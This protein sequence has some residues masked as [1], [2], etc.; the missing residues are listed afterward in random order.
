MEPDDSGVDTPV[1][2]RGHRSR[3]VRLTDEGIDCLPMSDTTP[4]STAAAEPNGDGMACDTANY[5]VVVIGGGFCGASTGILLKRWRP[6]IRVL[7]VEQSDAFRRKVGEA[8]VEVSSI[9]L[10]RVLGLYDHLAREHLPKHGLRYWFTDGANRQ[11]EEMSEVGPAEPPRL[12]SFQLDRTKLDQYLLA[13][14]A[15]EGCEVWRPAKVKTLDD[16][17]P[18]STL[19]L[20]TEDGPRAVTSRWVVDASGRYNFISRRKGLR[21]RVEN[22]R[23]A[24][25]W[26][27]WKGAADFDGR[28]VV[29]D[30]PRS[31]PL[32]HVAASRRLATNH[33]CGYGWWAWA[34]PLSGGETS[35]GVVYDKDLYALPEGTSTVE[36]YRAHL[37]A[38]DGLRQLIEG[39]ELDGDDFLAYSHLPYRSSQYMGRGWAL[40]GDAAAFIDPYY[41]PGLDHASMSIYATVRILVQELNGELDDTAL[42]SQLEEHNGN[43]HRSYD[44]W[45]AALYLGKYE[46]LGDAELTRTAFLFDTAMYYLGV[47][48]PLCKD[49]DGMALPVFGLDLPQAK[50]AYRTMQAFNGRLLKLARFRRQAGLYGR[51]NTGWRTYSK[52]FGIGIGPAL[53]PISKALAS[54][55][56]ME[57][58][59]L[60]YRLK[61]G[62][63]DVS[64]PVPLPSPSS[65]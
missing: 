34:I 50:V 54:W 25:V 23:T 37:T 6:G 26:G 41:S 53:P 10:H 62:R 3:L 30:D 21:Q 1:N 60:L 40:V 5:D 27:R 31:S 38:H 2:F 14:A 44:R 12:P 42:D 28:A 32:S 39:A 36:R 64:E 8:T 29:G 45:L 43:F 19:Q 55:L 16:A 18:V 51:R 57:G 13:T 63:A 24:A 11:L 22:H 33:F 35:I 61:G 17:W 48:T 52:S 56:R 20:D 46:I 15:E 59:R 49:I 9:F 47:V 58:E 7:V 65:R 4:L